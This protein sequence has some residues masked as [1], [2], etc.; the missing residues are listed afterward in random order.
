MTT[1]GTFIPFLGKEN[2]KRQ[3]KGLI[4]GDNN[5]SGDL[6]DTNLSK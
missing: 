1:V 5:I 6:S 3:F 4:K 2:H